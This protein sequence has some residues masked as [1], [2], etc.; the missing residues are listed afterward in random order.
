MHPGT[1]GG[2]AASPAAAADADLLGRVAAGEQE[3]VRL[4]YARHGR[5]VYSIAMGVLGDSPAAEEVTQDVFLRVWEKAEQYDPG[6][7]QP[8]TWLARIA[9]NRAIDVLRERG[10]REAHSREAWEE[11]ARSAVEADPA[12]GVEIARQ[13]ERVRLAIALLPE[14]Q[15][16]ALS[17]AFFQGLTHLQIARALG[18]PLGTVKTRIRDAMRRLRRELAEDA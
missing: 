18:E 14:A 4:L 8:V 2:R 11:L 10:T 17:L 5:L 12:E 15:R 7:S 16:R 9:R 13:K 1:E 6:R 3:A